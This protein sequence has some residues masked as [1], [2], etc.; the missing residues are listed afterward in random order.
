[1]KVESRKEENEDYEN[2]NKNED[3][4]YENEDEDDETTDQNKTI[5]KKNDHLD[6]II[7]KS[8]SF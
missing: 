6:E 5:K 2:E 3:E 8:K 4:D 7:D 1:M